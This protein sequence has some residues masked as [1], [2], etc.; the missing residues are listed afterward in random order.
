MNKSIDLCPGMLAGTQK[1]KVSQE[2]PEHYFT[3]G[4]VLVLDSR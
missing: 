1:V 2:T 3:E 4:A